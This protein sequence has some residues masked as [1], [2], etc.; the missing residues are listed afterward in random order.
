MKT[1]HFIVVGTLLSYL[2]HF[3]VSAELEFDDDI[4]EI[5]GCVLETGT[6]C[7]NVDLSGQDLRHL[8]LSDST[9]INVNFK[10]A[11]LRHTVMNRTRLKGCDFS[12]ADMTLAS[13]KHTNAKGSK[14][15]ETKMESIDGWAFFGQGANFHK[16]NL[17]GA[18]LVHARLAGAK[19]QYANLRRTY[20][21]C[22]DE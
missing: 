6:T 17:R 2:V 16:A 8:D 7:E 21:A 14:F 19:M 3:S 1:I 18:L 13:L 9:F 4:L 20:G 12:H 22:M 5:N 15:I 10:H 11:D